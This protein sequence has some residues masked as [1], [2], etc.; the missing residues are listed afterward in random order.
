[1]G[2]VPTTTYGENIGVMAITKVYSVWVIGGAAVFSIVLSFI[3][4]ASGLIMSIPAPV[5]GGVS[6]L[7]Y[8]M[9]AASGL[10]LLVDEKVDYSKA[11]NLALSSVVFITGLS[12]AFVQIG[13]VKLTGMCLATIVGMI[14]GLVFYILDKAKLTN[15]SD[16]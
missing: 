11:R 16:D 12:G 1:M 5:M 6:F 2:S 10:R 3:G 14:L 4:K 7:L 15:D 8:G 9:I 13:N